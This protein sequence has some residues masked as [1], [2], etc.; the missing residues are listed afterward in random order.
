MARPLAERIANYRLWLERKNT[1]PLAGLVWEP[2]IPPLPA[3]MDSLKVHTE[4]SP[5]SFDPALFLPHI[6]RWHEREQR[7]GY[8]TL[9]CYS[10]AFGMAWVEAIAGCRMVAHPGSLWA[11]SC[12][13][14]LKD[15]E[16]VIFDP[17]NPWLMKMI[18]FTRAMVRHSAGRYPVALPQMR[19]PLDTFAA[20]RTPEKMCMDFLDEPEESHKLLAE[21][22]ELWI[23][24]A[25]TVLKEIPAFHGGWASRMKMWAP[26]LTITPQNDVSTLFSPDLY[27]EQVLPFDEKI[28]AA[29]PFHLFHAHG[30]E[31]QHFPAFCDNRKLSALQI[32]LEHTLGGLALEKMLPIV[33]KVL[34]K[35][36]V[37]LVPLDLA[38]AEICLRE[39][40]PR[41]LFVMI[42]LQGDAIG[43]EYDGWIRAN[44]G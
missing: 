38:T 30:S 5:A 37:V 32:T 35:K 22:T 10:P 7:F 13:G 16:P 1:R 40:P 19:G 3:F 29:F 31:Y 15:R 39:L 36:P 8:D 42:G 33:R 12:I 25:R 41:G 18:A 4:I 34:E 17:R 27:R 6:D 23:N 14:N 20:M 11:E 21:L 44:C 26:G 43:S 9:Q 28:T 2:D 24:I